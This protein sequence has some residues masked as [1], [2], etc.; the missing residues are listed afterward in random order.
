MNGLYFPVYGKYT[1]KYTMNYWILFVCNVKWVRES[2]VNLPTKF[3]KKEEG[4][5]KKRKGKK[6]L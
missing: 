1:K 5:S 2:P 4:N 3:W 6:T